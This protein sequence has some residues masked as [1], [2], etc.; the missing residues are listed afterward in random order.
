MKVLS[1]CSDSFSYAFD[2]PTSLFLYPLI[3]M[4]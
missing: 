2:E 3:P 1:Q 4:K